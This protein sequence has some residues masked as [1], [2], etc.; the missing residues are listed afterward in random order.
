MRTTTTIDWISYT[1]K[2]VQSGKRAYPEYIHAEGISI[3]GNL[4]YTDGW[5]L[6]GGVRIYSNPARPDMGVHV[7]MSG[8]ALQNIVKRGH[9]LMTLLHDVLALG[10]T[11][12]RIDLAL[13]MHE[14][15]ASV[16]DF[17]DAFRD[18]KAKTN[19]RAFREIKGETAAAGHTA[20]IGSRQSERMMRVYDKAA[21]TGL[22]QETWVR[23][24][25]ELKGDRAN[26]IA[27]F[28]VS[29]PLKMATG[30]IHAAIIDF[31]DFP[32]IPDWKNALQGIEADFGVSQRK[33]TDTKRWLLGTCAKSL[34][35]Y[36]VMTDDL[37]LPEFVEH[38]NQW[39]DHYRATLSE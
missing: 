24:E 7:I 27:N 8:K 37:F 20:Y 1:I 32:T 14:T 22:Q 21:E 33:D 12:R 25:V 30:A 5:E 28:I 17:C 19:S 18:G 35:K 34:A 13:D 2:R 31:A 9:D 23:A 16:Q 11:I 10:A 38:F 36:I 26:G 4:G 39:V 29:L 3:R 15:M 6:V